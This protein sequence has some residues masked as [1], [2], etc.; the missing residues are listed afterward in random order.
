MADGRDSVQIREN[1]LQI[2]VGHV[3][4]IPPRHDRADSSCADAAGSDRLEELGL[5]VIADSG[6]V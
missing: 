6:R 2:I 5:I 4:E 1:C 3:T